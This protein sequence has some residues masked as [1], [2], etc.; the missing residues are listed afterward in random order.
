MLRDL[1]ALFPEYAATRGLTLPALATADNLEH[2]KIR[3]ALMAD[4][5]P[6]DLDDVLFL[7]GD[8][9]ARG[10]TRDGSAEPLEAA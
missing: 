7:V 9:Q 4:G 3:D 6:A 1:L 2:L 10:T 5:V 8:G